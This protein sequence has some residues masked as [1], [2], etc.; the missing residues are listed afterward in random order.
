M[1]TEA[2]PLAFTLANAVASGVGKDR[3]YAML[4][5]G[6]I[7]RAMSRQRAAGRHGHQAALDRQ[8]RPPPGHLARRQVLAQ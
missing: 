1:A 5:A 8:V 7:E 6:E 2:L 4:A 3:V